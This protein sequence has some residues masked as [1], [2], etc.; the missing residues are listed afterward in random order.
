MM[1]KV[2]RK[3]ASEPQAPDLTLVENPPKP[4]TKE[5]AAAPARDKTVPRNTTSRPWRDL[6]PAR[7]WPD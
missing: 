3:P 2:M 6:H 7:I 1:A 4:E 5:A